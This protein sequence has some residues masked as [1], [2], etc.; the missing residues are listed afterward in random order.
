MGCGIE[1]SLTWMTKRSLH[2]AAF[3][4]AK[5]A[6]RCAAAVPPLCPDTTYAPAIQAVK[7]PQPVPPITSDI[8][9]LPQGRR[10]HSCE[11]RGPRL[12]RSDKG[13]Y[14]RWRTRSASGSPIDRRF[15]SILEKLGAAEGFPP[16]K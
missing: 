5:T 1:R 8:L 10:W 15:C 9:Y 13:W 14:D 7:D 4:L 12:G 11:L 2:A 6:L 3:G 16:A